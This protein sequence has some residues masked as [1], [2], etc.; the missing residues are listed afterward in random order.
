MGEPYRH[1][2]RVRYAECD[3]QGV[4]FNA[5]YLAYFDTNMTEL[6]RVAFGSYQAM[7]DRGV[8][9]V[10]VD[11]QLQFRGSARFD[12]ELTLAV[13]VARLGNTSIATRHDVS[14]DGE[15]LVEG[16]ITHVIVE[17]ETLVKTQIPDWLR[18]GLE[19]WAVLD[20]A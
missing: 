17:R 12:D 14:R 8:D 1:P 7:L 16:T 19:P 11:A 6:W 10:V 2:L 18:A 4:V 13:S 3:M 5:H 15:V 9:M 20:G